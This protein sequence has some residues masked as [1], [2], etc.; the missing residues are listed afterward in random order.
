MLRLAVPEKLSSSPELPLD[1]I[2]LGTGQSGHLVDV[3]FGVSKHC[4]R[5]CLT[6]WVTEASRC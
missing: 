3:R 1:L 6:A 2:L 4:Q 5:V